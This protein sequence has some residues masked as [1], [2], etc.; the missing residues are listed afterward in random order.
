M[1]GSPS[2]VLRRMNFSS[3]IPPCAPA[4]MRSP[5]RLNRCPGA[6]PPSLAP[7]EI[8]EGQTGISYRKIICPLSARCSHCN[9][10]GSLSR[11][12]YQIYNLMSFIELLDPDN[13][14]LALQVITAAI[15]MR[16]KSAL[17]K[18][19]SIGRRAP[20]PRR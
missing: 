4:R 2:A 9:A 17:G 1:P 13:G 5:P 16:R 20:T 14:A 11:L 7:S 8:K 6:R 10:G 15:Q 19:G 3:F 18:T 12:D